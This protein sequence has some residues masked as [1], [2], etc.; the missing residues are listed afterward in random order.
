M[1]YEPRAP[2]PTGSF[3]RSWRTVTRGPIGTLSGLVISRGILVWSD[4]EGIQQA[5]IL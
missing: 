3:S 5:P 2:L 1:V 4:R